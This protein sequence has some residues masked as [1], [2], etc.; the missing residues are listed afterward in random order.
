[1]TGESILEVAQRHRDV[2]E[3]LITEAKIDVNTRNE[4]GETML[5]N[6]AAMGNSTNTIKYLLQH[7]AD[8][9]IKNS[10]REVMCMILL[11]VNVDLLCF[12]SKIFVVVVVVCYSSFFELLRKDKLLMTLL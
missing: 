9:A 1:M 6:L 12:Y 7:G 10:V 5:H 3:Y 4:D 11:L 8:K 2:L